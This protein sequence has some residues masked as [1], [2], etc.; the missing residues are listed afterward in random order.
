MTEGLWWDFNCT[1]RISGAFAYASNKLTVTF[2]AL[3]V[4]FAAISIPSQETAAVVPDLPQTRETIQHGLKIVSN[5][6]SPIR[7]KIEQ[8]VKLLG[9]LMRSTARRSQ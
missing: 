7:D 6:N 5:M 9:R 2:N 4:L 1:S 3:C 8:G